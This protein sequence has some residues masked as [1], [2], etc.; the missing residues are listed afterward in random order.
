MNVAYNVTVHVPSEQ[1]P[2]K[3]IYYTYHRYTITLCN[4]SVDV[5]SN[6]L[7]GGKVYHTTQ[8]GGCSPLCN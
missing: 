6:Y 2:V 1:T 3:M 5:S 4:V 7:A 8:V